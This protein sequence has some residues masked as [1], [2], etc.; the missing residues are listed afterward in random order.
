MFI[1]YMAKFFFDAYL[2]PKESCALV[3]SYSGETL[4]LQRV[5]KTFYVVIISL[6]S[7]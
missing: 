4:S 7:C 2:V 1:S 5:M 3:I 6:L